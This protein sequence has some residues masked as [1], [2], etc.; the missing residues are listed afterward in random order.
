MKQ[1]HA[2]EDMKLAIE[3]GESVQSS[4]GV[5]MR[6][7]AHRSVEKRPRPV[8][9]DASMIEERKVTND[10]S[11]SPTRED[12]LRNKLALID[13]YEHE[14]VHGKELDWK[15][16]ALIAKKATYKARLKRM[17]EE[18]GIMDQPYNSELLKYLGDPFRKTPA[19][20]RVKL[21]PS[22]WTPPESSF[23]I[24]LTM[25]M[26]IESE[27]GKTPK[28]ISHVDFMKKLIGKFP[29]LTKKINQVRKVQ[30]A[31]VMWDRS[32]EDFY[33]LAQP[34]P[35]QSPGDTDMDDEH[36]EGG[37]A[38]ETLDRLSLI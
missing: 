14:A 4:D 37:Y 7:R 24:G 8:S 5:V 12:T 11:P 16:R 35:N 3:S 31:T 38:A 2:V 33:R 17:E 26:D 32:A 13:E 28:I 1:I 34:Q 20:K 25:G 22:M 15:A 23:R 18:V 19:V 36:V 6:N 10:K 30:S 27:G 21:A 29:E 9:P